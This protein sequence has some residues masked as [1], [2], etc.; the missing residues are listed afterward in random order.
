MRPINTDTEEYCSVCNGNGDIV[1]EWRPMEIGGTV[2]NVITKLTTCA[3]CG[4]SGV[5]PKPKPQEPLNP[6]DWPTS[7]LI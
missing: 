7:T 6:D 3:K 4:G 1:T 2:I 5:V